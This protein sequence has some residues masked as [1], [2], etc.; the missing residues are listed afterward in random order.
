MWEDKLHIVYRPCADRLDHYQ[1]GE[2]LTVELLD[3]KG[4]RVHR[5]M[6]TYH[7]TARYVDHDDM[8]E[9]IG[10]DMIKRARVKKGKHELRILHYPCC[11][12]GREHRT[13]RSHAD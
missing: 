3:Y 10:K 7:H 2:Q 9:S 5:Q 1:E 8:L 12:C 11:I 13:T 4:A 6:Y